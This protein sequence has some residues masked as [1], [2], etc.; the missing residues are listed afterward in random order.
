MVRLECRGVPIE[1]VQQ[2][3]FNSSMVRLEFE[4][5]ISNDS[6]SPDFNSSMVR[7]EL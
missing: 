3:N 7:L 5:K 1:V 2:L 4:I 6:L